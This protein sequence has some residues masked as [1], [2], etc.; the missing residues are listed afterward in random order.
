MC[1]EREPLVDPDGVNVMARLLRQRSLSS[2]TDK[3]R[4]IGTVANLAVF[5]RLGVLPARN[6]QQSTFDDCD[7]LSG[8]TLSET[9]FARRHGCASCSIR[10]ERLFKYLNGRS[11]AGVRNR[12]PLGPCG[13]KE[14]E[15]VLHAAHLWN[16]WNGS[17]ALGT[18]DW[19]MVW[20]KGLC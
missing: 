13:Y 18:W 2:L 3:Y 15:A 17:L 19:A 16:L 6:F 8:E 14:T 7:A 9:S 11:N 10:C 4:N 12:I 5:N 1:G 20:Q